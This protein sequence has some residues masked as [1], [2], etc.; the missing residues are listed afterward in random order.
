VDTAGR[1]DVQSA[2]PIGTVSV[3]VEH[4]PV[5][6]HPEVPQAGKEGLAEQIVVQRAGLRHYRLLRF[7]Y[8]GRVRRRGIACPT[9]YSDETI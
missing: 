9:R 7:R 2:E 5:A 6:F 3:G 4:H 1:S 8:K